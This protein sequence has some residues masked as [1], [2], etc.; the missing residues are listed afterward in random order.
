ME[1][2]SEPCR[3]LLQTPGGDTNWGVGGVNLRRIFIFC[4]D[5]LRKC[6]H[7]CGRCQEYLF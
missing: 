2:E 4:C 3:G 6:S 7:G 1:G 5:G